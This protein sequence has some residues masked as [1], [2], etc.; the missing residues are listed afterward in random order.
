MVPEEEHMPPSRSNWDTIGKLRR[1]GGRIRCWFTGTNK[2][3]ILAVGILALSALLAYWLHLSYSRFYILSAGDGAAYE[4]DRQSGDTWILYKTRK[5]RHEDPAKHDGPLETVPHSERTKITGNSSLGY[6]RFSGK[7]YNG[8]EWV[9]KQVVFRVTA[10]EANGS[11]RWSRNFKAQ[12]RI[13][14]LTAGTFEVAVTGDANVVSHTWDISEVWG[15]RA[16]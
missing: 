2:F 4:V 11:V 1:I 12:M 13:E 9:I 16:N 8:S 6:G 7:L 5:T 3:A 15:C 10:K 14:P